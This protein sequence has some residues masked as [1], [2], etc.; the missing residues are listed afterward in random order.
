ML[1]EEPTTPGTT[2]FRVDWEPRPEPLT[3]AAVWV[4]RPAIPVAAWSRDKR[5]PRWRGLAFDDGLLLM[6]DAL[7]WV[8]GA[9]WLGRDPAAPSLILPTRLRP[10]LPVDLVAS[11]IARACPGKDPPFA[12][13]PDLGRIISLAHIGHIDVEPLLAWGAE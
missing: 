13:L 8:D 7:P 10:T 5:L 6:S 2:T 3:P 1:R 11:A 9:T 12:V 4:P